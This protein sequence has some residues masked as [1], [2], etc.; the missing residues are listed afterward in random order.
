[1]KRV[2]IAV[3]LLTGC[4]S[5]PRSQPSLGRCSANDYCVVLQ[6]HN[7]SVHDATVSLNGL[8]VT[9]APALGHTTSVVGYSRL[10]GARCALI[11]V[12]L[13]DGRRFRSTRECVRR[14]QRLELAINPLL[15]S[16]WLA[17]R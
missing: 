9:Q 7:S 17:P 8:R 10:D 1:M 3:A 15:S 16:S 4:A 13:I 5:I 2:L 11:E 6:I 14:G 12:R